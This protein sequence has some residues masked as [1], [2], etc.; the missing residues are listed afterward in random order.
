MTGEARVARPVPNIDRD[1]TVR[2]MPRPDGF[3]RSHRV[4][5]SFERHP[6]YQAI[7]G[8]VDENGRK[9]RRKG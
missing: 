3:Q 1:T 4:P 2:S 7:A 9:T 8:V 5:E 6:F